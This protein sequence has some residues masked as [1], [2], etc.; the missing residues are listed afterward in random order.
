MLVPISPRSWIQSSAHT[1]VAITRHGETEAVIIA[2]DDLEGLLET[3]DRLSTPGA[4]E[5]IRDA[6]ADIAAGNYTTGEDMA[7]IMARR[8]KLEGGA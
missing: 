1:T 2:A 3:L 8:K 5:E 6:T 4:V 7:E